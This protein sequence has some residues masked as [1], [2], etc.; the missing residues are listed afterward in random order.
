MPHEIFHYHHLAEVSAEAEKLNAFLPV[1]Q[2]LGPLYQPLQLGAHTVT[3]RIAF[4]PM[5]GTDGT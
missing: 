4:Q 1:R 2:D 3:N 5:E